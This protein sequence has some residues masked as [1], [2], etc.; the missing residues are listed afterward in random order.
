[1]GI[2]TDRTVTADRV[3]AIVLVPMSDT[4][5]N[6]LVTLAYVDMGTAMAELLGRDDANWTSLAVWPSFTVGDTIR[7]SD[8]PLGLKRMLGRGHSDPLG[9]AREKA[10]GRV[11]RGRT[12]DGRVLNRSLAAGNRGVFHE[13]GLCWA[14]FLATFGGKELTDDEGLVAFH[15][16]CDRIDRVPLPPG[17]L[18]PDGNRD[19]LKRAF[20]AYLEAMGCDDPKRKAELILLGNICMGDHE[21]RRLQGW[22][23]LS[24]LDPIRVAAKPIRNVA[25]GRMIGRVENGWSLVMTRKVFVVKMA[26]ETIR[27]GRP[28]PLDDGTYPAPLDTLEVPAV[29]E[30]Y[31]RVVS[32]G[33]G[34][35]TGAHHWNDFDDRMSFIASLFRARQRAGLVGVSPYTPE[36][37]AQIWAAAAEVDEKEASYELE[38]PLYFPKAETSPWSADVSRGL[39]SRLE[40]GRRQC[41]PPV[42]EVIETFYRGS[43]IPRTD[44]HFTDVLLAVAA[45]DGP[46]DDPITAFLRAEPVLPA[47]ADLDRIRSAQEFFRTFRP[48]IHASLFFGSMF[49]GYAAANGVQ[50]LALVSDLTNSPERRIW[51]STRFV[52]DVCTTP[53]WERD[54][55]GWK[56]IRGVRVYHG[57]VRAMIESGSQ[58]IKSVAEHPT[59]RVWDPA[60]GR[61]INQEDMFGYCLTMAVPTIENLDR[62]G[63]AID[64]E[65]ARDWLHLWN[66]IGFLMGVDES[67]LTSPVDPSRDLTFEEARAALDIVLARNVGPTPQ[68]R[69]LTRSLLDEMGWFPGPLRRVARSFIRSSIG[70]RNADMLGVPRARVLEPA[71]AGAQNV[72]RTLRQSRMS[73]ATSR[74]LTEWLGT[75]FLEW[76]EQQYRDTPPYRRGGA[77]AVAERAPDPSTRRP[78]H[79]SIRI[80]SVGELPADVTAAITTTPDV[81]LTRQ[82]EPESDDYESLDMQ[83]L[84][85]GTVMSGPAVGTLVTTL[86]Q[87]TRTV[88]SVREVEVTIDGR[89][90]P[91]SRLT[92]AEVAQLLPEITG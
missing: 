51:E 78:R 26:D 29:K 38:G 11:L 27:V 42:D 75:E 79:V 1:M 85:E 83:T 77:H 89:C 58:H 17:K 43:G 73:A 88:S 21:Q 32:A 68:G 87:A 91:L 80:D 14:D 81:D 13:I 56:S 39:A 22:L 31:D 12:K 23:D 25:S 7:A 76:W 64:P 65:R 82:P 71:L 16:L 24:M 6:H 70:D 41:D 19:Q 5:R 34:A 28:V 63:Q 66:V 33:G 55:A 45:P 49:L 61:P 62:M 4:L 37:E 35:A 50:V 40:A 10:T 74:R 52:E 15:E 84:L 9:L 30:E 46:E 53:F 72:A 48:S 59:D 18:W 2:L 47:W 90:V 86:R 69:Q 8:D 3:K 92:D 57:S 44:R 20:A 54:S 36:Q 60:W 67:L